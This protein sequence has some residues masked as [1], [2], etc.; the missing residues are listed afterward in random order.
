[1]CMFGF[2]VTHSIV[3]IILLKG[4]F[5]VIWPRLPL[6]IFCLIDVQNLSIQ[7]NSTQVLLEHLQSHRLELLPIA[8]T[9]AARRTDPGRDRRQ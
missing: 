8:D 1:M 4:Q 6:V 5:R 3:L 9:L 7:I 2:L